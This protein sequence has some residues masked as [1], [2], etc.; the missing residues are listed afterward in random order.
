MNVVTKKQFTL[1]PAAPG[2]CPEC[3]TEHPPELPHNWHSLYYQMRFMLANGRA[4]T[5][6]DATA[7]CTPEMKALWVAT[8]QK[9]EE[10]RRP[11]PHD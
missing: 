2:T 6:D 7:H 5:L 8:V 11:K 3:A 10:E 9:L 4:P 1:L